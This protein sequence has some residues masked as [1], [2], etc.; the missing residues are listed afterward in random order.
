VRFQTGIASDEDVAQAETQLDTALAQATNL[1]ILRSQLE[2]A[3][4]M[5]TGR[6]PA[7]LTLAAQPL[8][9]SPP[10]IPSGLP[11]QLLERRPDI[12]AAERRVAEANAQIG[13]GKAAYFP[14]VTLSAAG[15]LQS[16]QISS[17]L[18][19]SSRFWSIGA[20]LSETIFDA[21]QRHAVV[22]QLQAA[23]DS[24]VARYRQTV[25]T[26]F[27]QVEDNLSAIRILAQQ[28]EEQDAAVK[29]SQRYLNLAQDRYKLGIDSYLNV[30]TAQTTLLVNAQTL[31]NLRAQQMTATVQLIEAL[32][33]GWD[34]SQLPTYKR[35]I[36]KGP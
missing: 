6:A 20:G 15:G 25:L 4:A 3:I 34:D 2:H 32:G 11:S 24:S 23:H 5:L 14:N 30:I 16:T 31:V 27:Q 8:N 10:E 13:V 22:L 29:S 7:E 33:G 26:A 19:W 12:A 1:G 28:A 35:L 18:N 36:S 9:G 17:L 21:G